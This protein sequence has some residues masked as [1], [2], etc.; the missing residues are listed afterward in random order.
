MPPRA[1][2]TDTPRTTPDPAAAGPDDPTSPSP[3]P[4]AWYRPRRARP[5]SRPARTRPGRGFVRAPPPPTAPRPP[6]GG[7]KFPRP[8]PPPPPRQQPY[9]HHGPHQIELLFHRQRPQV[10]E[11][12]ARPD[13]TAVRHA[14]RDQPP[15]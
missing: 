10:Y 3:A 1:S 15:V 6:R 11:R 5:R 7:A 12:R 4:A 8:P 13:R 9:E 2:A 14:R